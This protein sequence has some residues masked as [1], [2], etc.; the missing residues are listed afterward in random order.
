MLRREPIR[1][2]DAVESLS[3]PGLLAE[4]WESSWSSAG[5]STCKE[6]ISEEELLIVS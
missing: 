3:L 2:S 4:C 1:P 6:I 5:R